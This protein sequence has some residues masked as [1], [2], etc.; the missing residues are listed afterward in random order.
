VSLDKGSEQLKLVTNAIEK[1][2][3]DKFE[4][5]WEVK[6]KQFNKATNTHFLDDGDESEYE[7]SKGKMSARATSD[8]KRIKPKIYNKT[9]KLVEPDEQR[10]NFNGALVDVV[11]DIYAQKG[12]YEGIRCNLHGVRLREEGQGGIDVSESDFEE[13]VIEDDEELI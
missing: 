2:L 9:A 8:P 5:K 6:L 13:I 12:Q 4:S 11:L 7:Y 3:K 10:Y 1:E